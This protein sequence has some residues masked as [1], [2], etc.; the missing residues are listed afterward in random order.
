M[1]ADDACLYTIG[2]SVREVQMSL[3]KYVTNAD[4]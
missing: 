3:L 2:K 4:E 1:F